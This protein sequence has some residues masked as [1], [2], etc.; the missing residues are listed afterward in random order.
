MLNIDFSFRELEVFCKVVELE[1]FSKAAEAVFLVQASV[2]ERIASLEK[3]IG[4]RLLDR[5]GRKVI[6]TAAGELLY[7]HASLLLEMRETAQL[8]IEKFLGLEQG[9]ISM[10]GSTIPGEYILPNL[11]GRFSKKYPH[12][13]V[14]LTIAD[15]SEIEKQVLEGQLEIGVIG[16]KSSHVNLLCQKLWED[17]LVLAVPAGHP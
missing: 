4:I 7:K 3:K 9:E 6:P 13:A 15:S 14:R 12:L 8:E 5:L 17:E 2:S 1:S 11:I 16:S 10:G